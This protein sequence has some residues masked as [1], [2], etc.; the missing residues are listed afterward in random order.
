MQQT[1]SVLLQVACASKIIS[2]DLQ[3]WDLYYLH[4]LHF[5]LRR[6]GLNIQLVT[7]DM[8]KGGDSTE[9]GKEGGASTHSPLV[10]FFHDN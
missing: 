1:N 4:L 3:T 10:G 5:E 9:E 8:A 7:D 6:E 2:R